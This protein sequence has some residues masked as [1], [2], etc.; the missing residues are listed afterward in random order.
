MEQA[1]G[2]VEVYLPALL[3]NPAAD[4]VAVNRPDQ[5]ALDRILSR[6]DVP[7]GYTNYREM[8]AKEAL[9]AVVI[10]SPHTLHF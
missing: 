5:D 1:G 6:F 7:N 8:L 10:T 9:D 4:L 2:G 3:E